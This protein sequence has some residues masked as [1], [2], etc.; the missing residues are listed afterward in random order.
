M[1]KP[2][3]LAFIATPTL[4]AG[5][6]S[7]APFL[8]L[9]LTRP[10]EERRRYTTPALWG[11]LAPGAVHTWLLIGRHNGNTTLTTV[12]FLGLCLV[13]TVATVM[14]FFTLD[15]ITREDAPSIYDQD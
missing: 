2:L 6:L 14:V 11:A 10:K 5:L 15:K 4:S 12:A 3:R 1:T 8:W 13:I 7:W 9:L